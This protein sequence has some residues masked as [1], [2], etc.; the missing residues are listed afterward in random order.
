M[1]QPT[2]RQNPFLVTLVARANA[3]A[4][5]PAAPTE[6]PYAPPKRYACECGAA[7]ELELLDPLPAGWVTVPAEGGKTIY[8]CDRCVK[9]K[10]GRRT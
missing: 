5:R 7:V 9:P 8:R 4:L 3:S 10:K 2:P 6:H 1:T